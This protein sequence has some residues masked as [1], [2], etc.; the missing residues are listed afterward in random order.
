MGHLIPEDPVIV[1]KK[2]PHQKKP[3]RVMY[4]AVL[5]DQRMKIKEN[6]KKDKYLDQ[7]RELKTMEHDG[8][9]VTSCNWGTLNDPQRFGKGAGRV[10]NRR[11]SEAI[12]TI[13]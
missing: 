2:H 1:N 6:K 5:A 8:N 9:S 3:C 11:T 13:G 7:A 10:G 4:F 12:Q